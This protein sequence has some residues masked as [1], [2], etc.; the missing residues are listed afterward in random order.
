MNE[1][2]FFVQIIHEIHNSFNELQKFR[3]KTLNN[4]AW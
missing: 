4:K 1:Y 2:D 3:N